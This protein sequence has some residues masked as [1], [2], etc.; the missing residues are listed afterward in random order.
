MKGGVVFDVDNLIQ[1]R[2]KLENELSNPDI[3]N[4]KDRASQ[5][6]REMKRIKRIIEPW[7]E[8]RKEVDDLVEL[9]TM[10]IEEK[11]E[12]LEPEIKEILRRG[13][14]WASK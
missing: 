3:W 2:G 12:E 11:E 4:N 6:T 10:A 8:A 13:M 7:V 5:V 1:Q 9:F 14:L